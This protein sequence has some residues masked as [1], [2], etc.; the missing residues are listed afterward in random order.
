MHNKLASTEL[1]SGSQLEFRNLRF[2][3]LSRAENV[4]SF[5]LTKRNRY[6]PSVYTIF[7]PSMVAWEHIS[8]FAS[9]QS[10]WWLHWTDKMQIGSLLSPDWAPPSLEHRSMWENYP[11]NCPHFTKPFAQID[12]LWVCLWGNQLRGAWQARFLFEDPVILSPPCEK[13]CAERPYK[14]RRY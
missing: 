1:S 7:S 12:Q 13:A 6:C 9:E 2:A 11:P 14:D 5:D 3:G 4:F 10:Q 8:W